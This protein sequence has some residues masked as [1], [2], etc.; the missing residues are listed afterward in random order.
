VVLAF[1]EGFQR[2]GPG[3]IGARGAKDPYG[4]PLER[5]S[6]QPKGVARGETQL[7]AECDGESGLPLGGE[8]D[9]EHDVKIEVAALLF[10]KKVRSAPI[11]SSARMAASLV[12]GSPRTGVGTP[13]L[14]FVPSPTCPRIFRP[15]Q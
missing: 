8:F 7:F 5:A 13:R 10:K 2:S 15:Q 14:P 9:R 11:D 6:L 12:H 1:G 4:L 3:P